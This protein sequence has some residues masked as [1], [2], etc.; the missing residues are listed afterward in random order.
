MPP[1]VELPLIS[2]LSPAPNLLLPLP[3]CLGWD[4]GITSGEDPTGCWHKNDREK[5]RGGRRRRRSPTLAPPFLETNVRIPH[6]ATMTHCQR[7]CHSTDRDKKRALLGRCCSG[8]GVRKANGNKYSEQNCSRKGK[9]G[10]ISISF[11]H[12][13]SACS[14]CMS[15]IVRRPSATANHFEN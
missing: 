7:A 4:G 14:V 10:L 12:L 1:Y 11:S 3:F 15:Y 2:S 8:Y 9:E 5:R 6:V 13:R